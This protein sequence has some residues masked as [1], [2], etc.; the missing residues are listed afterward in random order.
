MKPIIEIAEKNKVTIFITF[1]LCL[2][3]HGFWAYNSILSQDDWFSILD[4]NRLSADYTANG[5]WMDNVIAYLTFDRLFAPGFTVFFFI[6]CLIFCAISLVEYLPIKKQCSKLIFCGTFCVF[7]IWIETFS[8][9]QLHVS[10]GLA[11]IFCTYSFI[12]FKQFLE[13]YVRRDIRYQDFGI[14]LLLL[15]LSASTYQTYFFF[16]LIAL[17]IYLYQQHITDAG[18]TNGNLRKIAAVGVVFVATFAVAYIIGLRLSAYI[19][20]DALGTKGYYD[21]ANPFHLENLGEQIYSTFRRMIGFLLEPQYMMPLLT[22]ITITLSLIISFIFLIKK[23][24]HTL[25]GI[26]FIGSLIV[27]PWSLGFIRDG[28][29]HY[30]YNALTPLAFSIAYLLIYPLENEDFKGTFSKFYVGLLSICLLTFCFKN[31][32]ATYALYLSNQRDIVVA[33]QFL[34]HLHNL[35][36]YKSGKTY[37]IRMY[38]PPDMYYSTKRPYITPTYSYGIGFNT[39]KG[40]GIMQYRLMPSLIKLISEEDF[41]AGRLIEKLEIQEIITKNNLKNIGVWPEKNAVKILNDQTTVV[42]FFDRVK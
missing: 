12:Y 35:D 22:K 7:P 29:V 41:L 31:S 4:G 13:H 15:F 3:A 8:F 10:I 21:I 32:A 2:L 34:N 9:K 30:R 26:M 25:L 23:R 5:R 14:A 36:N 27:I 18:I 33:Q 6:F 11:M 28:F 39:M 38:G 1:I 42:I 20:G 40:S 24:K 16:F 37:T 17:L 19:T